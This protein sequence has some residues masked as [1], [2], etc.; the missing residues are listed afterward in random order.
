MYLVSN[1]WFVFTATTEAVTGDYT[2]YPQQRTLEE[3]CTTDT[4]PNVQTH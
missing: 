3:I 4:L 2:S 1:I